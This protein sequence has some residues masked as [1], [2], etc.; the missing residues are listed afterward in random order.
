MI[1]NII[2][3]NSNR[4]LSRWIVFGFDLFIVIL[5]VPASYLLRFNF[6]ISFLNLYPLFDQFLILSATYCLSFVIIR[7]FSGIIRHTSIKDLEKILLSNFLALLVGVL[8]NFSLLDNTTLRIPLSIF[9]IQFL[10]VT[11]IMSFARFLIKNSYYHFSRK[12]ISKRRVIIYGAGKSGLVTKQAL[13]QTEDVMYQIIGF[14]DDNQSKIGKNLEGIPVMNPKKLNSQFLS[15]LQVDEIIFAIQSI[16]STSKSELIDQLLEYDVTVKNIPPVNKWIDGEFSA[17]QIQN[18]KIEDLLEREQ[19]SLDDDLVSNQIKDRVVMVTGA[20]GSIGSEISKQVLN[21]KPSRLILIEQAESS[22]HDLEIDLRSQFNGHAAKCIVSIICDVTNYDRLV[23]IFRKYRPNLVYH[24]AAYKHVPLMELNPSEAIRTNIFGTKN[25]A[26][27]SSMFGVDNFVFISTDKAVNPT[28]V[29]G[30]SKR[31]AEMYCQSLVHQETKFVTTRFGNVLGSNGSVIPLFKK[32]IER[33]GP[34]TVTHQ[35]ITRFFMT[36]PEAC[37][38]VLEAGAMGEGGEIFVFDMG[39]QIRIYDLARKM[40]RL[41]GFDEGEIRVK[42][43]GLRPGEKLYEEV[44]SKEEN[45]KR[46]Y[47]PKISIAKVRSVNRVKLESQLDQL[48]FSLE[49]MDDVESVRQMKGIV[50]EFKSQNSNFQLLDKEE[51]VTKGPKPKSV[52]VS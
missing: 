33:G 6:D 52:R 31:I 7:P 32:Q 16:D 41:S 35:E 49:E 12:A 9:L 4:F 8:V 17:R 51:G 38:L 5:A 34:V 37:G 25:V 45:I 1:K 40:I 26:D 2:L 10:I 20:A 29:M 50:P 42:F 47:H 22:L 18:V 43:T 39:K 19:I 23:S 21:Y 30:A 15:N 14:L 44:L 3:K 36:I 24:A 28:N 13:E 48:Y 27:I 11:F 46:T